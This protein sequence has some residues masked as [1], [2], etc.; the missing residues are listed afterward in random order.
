[1]AM[2]VRVRGRGH[3]FDLASKCQMGVRVRVCTWVCD[4]DGA[5]T[6]TLT[7]QQIFV[8]NVLHV[9]VLGA[10]HHHMKAT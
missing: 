9:H 2:G 7:V 5:R 1:M 4:Y 3:A 8:N 6:K 10:A